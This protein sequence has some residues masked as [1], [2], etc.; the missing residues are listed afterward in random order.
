MA[1]AIRIHVSFVFFL[2]HTNVKQE[3]QAIT[4][5]TFADFGI[6][7]GDCRTYFGVFGNF[8][9]ISVV[10]VV[11]SVVTVVIWV[12]TVVISVFPGHLDKKMAAHAHATNRPFPPASID[13]GWSLCLH[14]HGW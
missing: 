10:M 4:S 12:E 13:R 7:Y 8:V 6:D 1:K 14:K 11:I 5:H 9:V 2:L 3:A